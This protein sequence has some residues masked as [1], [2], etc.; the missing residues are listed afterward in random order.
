MGKIIINYICFITSYP[1]YYI[2]SL[3]IYSAAF[4][5]HRVRLDEGSVKLEI[6]DTAGQERYVKN[7]LN[8]LIFITLIITFIYLFI[9]F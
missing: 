8:S 9:I 2:T 5:T 3:F 4:M 6:W 1:L 7:N